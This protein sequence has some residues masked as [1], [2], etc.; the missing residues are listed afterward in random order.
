MAHKG[1]TGSKSSGGISVPTHT[2]PGGS[3]DVGALG[4]VATGNVN[5][6]GKSN[7][8]PGIGGK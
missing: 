7:Q 8:K 3:A 2:S 5:A 1:K 6:S 4:R